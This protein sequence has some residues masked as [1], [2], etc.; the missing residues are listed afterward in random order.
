MNQSHHKTLTLHNQ[1]EESRLQHQFFQ[2][3]STKIY[4]ISN[5]Q[6]QVNI[7]FEWNSML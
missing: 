5:L 2:S 6:I 1:Q 3:N 4:R 7:T